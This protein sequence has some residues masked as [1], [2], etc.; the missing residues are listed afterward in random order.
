MPL[1][2]F[3][4]YIIKSLSEVILT[5]KCCQTPECLFFSPTR[6]LNSLRKFMTKFTV[7]ICLWVTTL[8][9]YK[10]QNSF[11]WKTQPPKNKSVIYTSK[12]IFEHKEESKMCIINMFPYQPQTTLRDRREDP[13]RSASS[14]VLTHVNTRKHNRR[15]VSPSFEPHL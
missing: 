11:S 14:A 1:L 9:N 10:R 7:K 4:F 2:N 6:W 8:Q 3:I 12:K 15:C 5:I 13:E